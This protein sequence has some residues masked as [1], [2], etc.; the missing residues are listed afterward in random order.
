MAELSRWI[1]GVLLAGC[2]VLGLLLAAR[3]AD[4]GIYVHGL[5]FFLFGVIGVF[6]LIARES[7]SLTERSRRAPERE[8]Y[9]EAIVRA[10]V[11]ASL[12]WGVV[13]FVVGVVIAFQ[14]VW[15]GLNLD[16]PW[17]SF[18]RLRPLHTSAVIFAFGGNVLLT[19]SFFV[20]QRTCR[21][22]LA[23]RWSPWFVFWGY[24]LFILLAATGYLLG[25]T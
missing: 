4:T 19:T 16:L 18:G 24:Q 20:V 13:G 8:S 22:R 9:N 15:P 23:G 10:G 2:A 7:V 14:L 3:A 12:F 5:L 17:T 11:I 1:W 6:W 25:I 21:V